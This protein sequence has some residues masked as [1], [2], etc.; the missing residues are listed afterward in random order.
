MSRVKGS[1]KTGGRKPG[2]PNKGSVGVQAQIEQ[3]LGKTLPQA[4]LERLGELEAPDAVR[5]ML[6]LMN[7]CYARLSAVAFGALTQEET[8][9]LEEYKKMPPEELAKIVVAP[10]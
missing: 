8:T 4:I 9:Q 2:T 7:Y 1:P 3:Y 5:A 10:Q 6:D